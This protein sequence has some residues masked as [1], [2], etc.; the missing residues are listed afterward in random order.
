MERSVSWTG[1]SIREFPQPGC[2]E[3]PRC[4]SAGR[5]DHPVPAIRDRLLTRPLAAAPVPDHDVE[6]GPE[7]RPALGVPLV[8]G[9]EPPPEGDA[10]AAA[11]VPAAR[12]GVLAVLGEESPDPRRVQVLGGV[13]VG[14]VAPDV[15]DGVAI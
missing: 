1:A 11:V 13:G 2:R 3:N 9:P 12:R 6:P 4:R 15:D 8:V 5:E 14:P 10:P 7:P